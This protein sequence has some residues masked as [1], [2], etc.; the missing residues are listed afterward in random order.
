MVLVFF[1]IHH[2]SSIYLSGKK[3]FL[4]LIIPE[5]IKNFNHKEKNITIITMDGL[6]D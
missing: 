6:L 4:I 2:K 3:E 1:A 5:F